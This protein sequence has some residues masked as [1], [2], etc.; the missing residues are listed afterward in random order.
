MPSTEKTTEKKYKIDSL[1]LE[2]VEILESNCSA[3]Y[4][5]ISKR[6]GKNI[7]TVRDRVNL[8]RKREIIKGCRGIIDYGALGFHCEAIISFNL[9][10]N[11]IDDS[12]AF[13]NKESRIKRVTV[14]SGQR[15]FSILVIGTDCSE[16]REYARTEL[17][18]FGIYDV[19]FEVILDEMVK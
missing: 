8:L 16:I 3:T 9:P 2:I 14:T 7:W 19:D 6:T 15:R 18:K 11:R 10:P 4:D 5:E 17:P 13:F 12:I 1:D